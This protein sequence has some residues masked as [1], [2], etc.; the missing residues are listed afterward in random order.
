MPTIYLTN[1]SENCQF[2]LLG[3]VD[4]VRANSNN[5]FHCGQVRRRRT[6]VRTTQRVFTVLSPH[7]IKAPPVE[8]VPALEL[9]ALQECQGGSTGDERLQ[10]DRAGVLLW[11]RLSHGALTTAGASDSHFTYCCPERLLC[12]SCFHDT[13]F[14]G[15]NAPGDISQEIRNEEETVLKKTPFRSEIITHYLYVSLECHH[16]LKMKR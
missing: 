16:T 2:V 9:L 1:S 7:F 6:A 14:E 15:R 3:G 13:S 10:A 5:F 8:D 4:R 12:P 11:G